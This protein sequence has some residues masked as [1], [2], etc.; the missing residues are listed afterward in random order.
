MTL[1]DLAFGLRDAVPDTATAA[2]GGRFIVT[3]DGH[4]DLPYDRSS[5]VGDDEARKALLD[6]LRST[7]PSEMLFKVIRSKL[8]AREL[9]TRV[10]R[11]VVL[12]DD[13]GIKVVANTHASAG[14]LYVAAWVTDPD[15]DSYTADG[16]SL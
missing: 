1:P 2:W 8:L 6:K 14:Y 13:N 9:D 3:M 11:D 7:F 16:V 4:V 12:F 5:A 10:E 15:Y